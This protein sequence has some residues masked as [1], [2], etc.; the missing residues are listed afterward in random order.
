MQALA[1]L[2][3]VS[4]MIAHEMNNILTPLGSYAQLSINNPQDEELAQKALKKTATNSA[5]AAQILESVLSMANGREQEKRIHQLK[6]LIDEIFTCL[7]RDFSKD[8]IQVKIG[9]PEQLKVWAE[10]ICL[11]QVLMNLVLNA[12]EAMLSKGGTLNISA[13]ELSDSVEII[14]TDSG[15]G[16]E[17]EN[18]KKIF[19]PFYT[20]KDLKTESQRKGAGLGLAFCNKVIEANN[21]TISVESRI[22]AGTTFIICLPKH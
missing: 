15:C 16:I 21:G 8:N 1:N 11:Q 13:K 2:G 22:G 10:G 4:A 18:L 7:A 19:E 17:Q 5:R 3:M 12:R 20:T 9:V 6:A 14:I